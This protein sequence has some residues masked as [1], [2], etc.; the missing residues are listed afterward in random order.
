MVWVK[1]IGMKP[2]YVCDSCGLCYRE[3]KTALACE[4][5][6]RKNRACLPEITK[7]ALQDS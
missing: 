3:A 5:F 6:C 4:A 2:A 7:K 1:N